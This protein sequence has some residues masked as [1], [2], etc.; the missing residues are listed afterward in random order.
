MSSSTGRRRA[1]DLGITPGSFPTGRHNAITDVTGVRVGHVTLVSGDD[2]RTGATAILPHEGNPWRE[3]VPAGVSVA[4]GFG[5]LIGVTQVRELG[6]LESPVVLT[7]T[8]SAPLAA[9]ALITWL[10]SQNGM[11]DAKSLNPFVGETN[12]GRLNDIRRRSV[13]SDHVLQ[14]LTSARDGP[15][16]EGAVGA[17]T[18]TVC[19]GYKGGIGTSSRVTPDG[20]TTGVLVQTNFGGQLRVDGRVVPGPE[21]APADGSVMIIVATDAPLSDRNLER[22]ARRAT[23]GLARTGADFS[24]GSGDYALAFSTA[25]EVRRVAGARETPG[26]LANDLVSPLFVAAADAAEEAILNSLTMAETTTGHD[27][28]RAEALPLSLLTL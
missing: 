22:L 9:D 5:K 11:E 2:V 18:G 6:E 10:L 26:G 12:D 24:N 14:A 25:A 21:D 8:L 7:N 23:F 15:V 28:Y 4:N 27:G 13:T 19:F 17:G 16:E 3:R 20:Y 1:R